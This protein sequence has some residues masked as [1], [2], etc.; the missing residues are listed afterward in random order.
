MAMCLV[1]MATALSTWAEAIRAPAPTHRS[2][3]EKLKLVGGRGALRWRHYEQREKDSC[4]FSPCFCATCAESN[5]QLEG[6]DTSCRLFHSIKWEIWTL[7]KCF[8][9]GMESS[10]AQ[11]ERVGR[12]ETT[13][14]EFASTHAPWDW[15]L[16]YSSI[17]INRCYWQIDALPF[18]IFFA[19]SLRLQCVRTKCFTIY[20]H[21]PHNCWITPLLW[22]PTFLHLTWFL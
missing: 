9:L 20:Q 14:N 13:G 16:R 11:L 21:L 2:R 17:I 19:V 5:K 8:R 22:L 3:D 6:S 18:N 12:L 4:I 10:D 7:L 15:S 1:S